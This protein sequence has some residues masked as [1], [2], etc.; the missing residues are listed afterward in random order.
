MIKKVAGFV[1]PDHLYSKHSFRR[2]R[3]S[4]QQIANL[5]VIFTAYPQTFTNKRFRQTSVSRTHEATLGGGT[6]STCKVLSIPAPEKQAE[7]SAFAIPNTKYQLIAPL[8]FL[9]ETDR[10]KRW[11]LMHRGALKFVHTLLRFPFACRSVL[12]MTLSYITTRDRH[13]EGRLPCAGAGHGQV[14]LSRTLYPRVSSVLLLIGRE[15]E[16]RLRF[17]S[18]L[19]SFRMQGRFPSVGWSLG[20]SRVPTLAVKHLDAA[21]RTAKP[22]TVRGTSAAP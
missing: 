9:L 1:H 17:N 10:N 22:T 5:A 13:R 6:S 11:D 19:T 4:T 15:R 14:E 21:V 2:R 3:C 12:L 16:A 8:S 20:F 7:G 18:I